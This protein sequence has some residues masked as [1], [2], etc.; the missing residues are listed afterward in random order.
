MVVVR[1]ENQ[2]IAFSGQKTAYS[3]SFYTYTERE[4]VAVDTRVITV[5]NPNPLTDHFYEN[6]AT[7]AIPL[8]KT[9]P[10]TDTVKYI[11]TGAGTNPQQ[12][13]NDTT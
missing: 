13:I 7:S 9:S 10:T 5:A 3:S 11:T 6:L 8:E 1:V 2:P 12:Y 4:V